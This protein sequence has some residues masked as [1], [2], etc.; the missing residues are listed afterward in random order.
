MTLRDDLAAI[1]GSDPTVDLDALVADEQWR[2]RLYLDALAGAGPEREPDL[3]ARVQRDPDRIMAESVLLTHVDSRAA[4]LREPAE[5]T[6]WATATI[7]GSVDEASFL[8]RRVRE[9]QLFQQV[10]GG[11]P[12][13]PAD[14]AAASNW[15][16]RKVVEES[17]SVPALTAMGAAG[18]TKRVRNLARTRAGRLSRS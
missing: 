13:D 6:A 17:D 5:F 8:A 11:G 1:V 7:T 2:Y 4:Q 15:L 12:V 3:V 14:L 10:S 18:R 16:Q 9:W